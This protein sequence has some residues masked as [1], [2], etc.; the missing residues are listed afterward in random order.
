MFKQIAER[1]QPSNTRRVR[2]IRLHHGPIF[3][4]PACDSLVFFMPQTLEWSGPLNRTVL[5]RAGE[6]LDSYVL[7]HVNKPKPGEVFALPPFSLPYRGLFMAVLAEWD[8]GVDFND[9]DLLNCYRRAIDLAQEKGFRTIAFPALG[10]DKMDFP[11]IRFARL[12]LQGI[13]DR[14]DDRLEGVTIACRDMRMMDIY[15]QRLSKYGWS[16]SG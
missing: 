7:D 11:H 8:G 3:D 4:A 5:A 15:K 12:A 13:L 1:L 14:L 6:S 2:A 9:R 10:R 16:A